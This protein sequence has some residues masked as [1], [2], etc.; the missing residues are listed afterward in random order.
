MKQIHFFALKDDLLPVLEAVEREI[1]IKYILMGHFPETEFGSFS[2]R[3]Q[4]PA[5]GQ[6]TTESASSGRSFLVTGHAVPIEVRPIKTPSGTRYSLDQ[7]SNP[8][9]VTFS[10]G[11]R[12]TEDVV[13]NG[14]VA[15]VSDTPLAQELMKTFNRAFKKQFSKIKAFYVGPGAAILL[16]AGKRLTAAE[17]S[18]REFDLT[19][20]AR[21]A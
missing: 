9:T 7:L 10:P 12:W 8:D 11:G 2:N 4:I 20:E 17:Q 21:V 19:R 6:S 13:I 1:S 5:L 16:D 3:M 15:T 14:R 18:P